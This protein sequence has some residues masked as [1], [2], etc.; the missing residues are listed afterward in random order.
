MERAVA[1]HMADSN[2]V[3]MRAKDLMILIMGD[4]W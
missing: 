3:A 1:A 2:E 4:I